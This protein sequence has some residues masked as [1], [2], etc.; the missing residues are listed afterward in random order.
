MNYAWIKIRR[1]VA[2]FTASDGSYVPQL[3]PGD[4]YRLPEPDARHLEDENA[5][6]IRAAPIPDRATFQRAS[7]LYPLTDGLE[8]ETEAINNFD[9]GGADAS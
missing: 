3:I 5:G 7:D 9:R 4:L 8:R 1:K 6:T 2:S